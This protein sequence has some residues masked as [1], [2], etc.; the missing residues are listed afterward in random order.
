MTIRTLSTN[1]TNQTNLV[2]SLMDYEPFIVAHLVKFERPQSV[3]HYGGK[4]Q[5][6]ATDFT[7]ISDAQYDISFD[8]GGKTVSGASLGP[9]LYRANKL[10]K[11]GV[12]NESIQA[13]ASNL[14]LTLDSATLGISETI[15]ASFTSTHMTTNVDLAAEGFREGDKVLLTGSGNTNNGAYIRID[16]FSGEGKIVAFTQISSI[17]SNSSL[18]TYVISSASEEINSLITDKTSTSYTS[19]INRD[20]LIYRVHINPD[21]RAIIG[22]PY[23]YFKGIIGSADISEKLD[24]ST[25]TWKLASHWGD[26]IRVQGRLTDDASHRA[27]Q[28]G[29]DPDLTAVI[30]PEYA[31]DLGFLHANTAVN[32][33]ATYNTTEIEYKQVDINGSWFGGKR[34][35]E[36]EVIVPR[37]TDLQFNIQAKM[38]PVVYGVRK[39]DSFP[40]FVDTHKDTSAE[41]YRVDALCEGKIAGILDIH[42]EDNSTI[43]T[44]LPDFDLRNAS[45]A[46]YDS[47]SVEI[48]C[49]GRADRGDTMSHYSARAGAG[50]R[51][52][53]VDHTG[54]W[55]EIA[56]FFGTNF[57]IA[58]TGTTNPTSGSAT[59]ILHGGTH[60]ITSPLSASFSFYQGKPYQKADN[61]LVSLASANNFK[62]QN[63][64]YTG[65]STYWGA[66]HK[67]LDTAYCV[68]KYTI[69]EGETSLPDLKFIVRGRDPECYNYDGSYR[70]DATGAGAGN[71]LPSVFVLG[72]NVTLHRTDN[73]VAIGGTVQIVDKWS[74]FDSDGVAD[75]RFRWSVRPA[76]GTITAFYMKSGNS[77][78]HMQTWDHVENAG[79]VPAETYVTVASTTTG[80][81]AG[82][83]VTVNTPS[84]AL[85]WLLAQEDLGLA[86]YMGAFGID[87]ASAFRDY[88]AASGTVID[89]V[90]GLPDA[91]TGGDKIYV[92]DGITLESGA[93][94]ESGYYVGNTITVTDISG[95]LVYTQV[96][97]ITGYDGATRTATVDAVWDYSN[98]PNTSTKYVI[99]SIGDKRV[100]INPAMQLL[101]Y[102]TNDR[103]GKGL[104]IDK[105]IDLPVWIAAAADC[106]TRS[107]VSIVVPSSTSIIP[108]QKWRYPATGVLQ[109]Q[110]TVVSVETRG[111]YKEI[112][113]DDCIGKLGTKWNDWKTFAAGELYW[114]N[115]VAYNQGGAAGI[116]GTKPTGTSGSSAVTVTI[117]KVTDSTTANV[118]TSLVSAN[119][120][121][122]VK[123]YSASSLDYAASGYSLYD[124][125]DVKY[126]RYVGWDDPAQRFVTRHQTNQ[127]VATTNPLFDNINRM[128]SQFNGILRYSGGRYQLAVKGKK[129]VSVNVAEQISNDDIIGTIKLSDKGLKNSKNFVSTSII[130]PQNKFEGRSVSFFN[131]VYLK[132]DKGIQ[133]KGSFSLPGVTNYHNARFNIKQY[134]DESRYGLEI[135][136]RMA[137]RGLLLLAG[138]IIELTY[139]RFGYTAKEFRITNLNFTKDGLVDVTADEHNDSAYVVEPETHGALGLVSDVGSG[140]NTPA[141]VGIPNRPTGLVCTQNEQSAITLTWTNTA[142]FTVGTHFTEIYRSTVNNFADSIAGGSFVTGTKY[143]ILTL[144]ST[145]QAQWNTAA[146]STAEVYKAGDTIIAAGS[147]AGTGTV[148]RSL[149]V[150]SS[151]SDGYT[152]PITTGT[153]SQNRYYWIRYMNKQP[154][155]NRSGGQFRNVPSLYYPNT[156]DSGFT[157]GQ[158]VTGVGA[159]NNAV[160]SI[161]LSFGNTNTFVYQQDGTGIEAGYTAST[162][163]TATTTNVAG[164]PT[165][166]WKKTSKTGTVSIIN[167]ITGVQ[168][169]YSPPNAFTDIPETISVHMTDTIGSDTYTATDAVSFSGTKI[170]VNGTAGINGF[171][172]TATNGTHNFN[173]G[174]TGAI[175]STAPFSSSFT[176][177]KGATTLTYDGTGSPAA[178]TYRLGS[179]ANVSPANSVVPSNTNGAV[180]ISNSTGSFLTGNSV[181]QATFDVPIIENGSNTTI[182][183]FKI[184]LSKTLNGSLGI[185]S[186]LVYAYQRSGTTLTS[187]P[188]AV[189]VS[190]ETGKI[191]TTS[192][193]NGWYK[194]LSDATG[195]TP[196]YITAASA[197]GTG[198]T[199]T[200]PANEWTTPLLWTRN[201]DDGNPGINSA[202]VFIYKRTNS[203]SES[204]QPSGNTTY[205]FASGGVA[206][207]TANGW[208]SSV[209]NNTNTYVWTRQATAAS[210]S[211]TDVIPA[212]EWGP[213]VLTFA[214]GGTG[215]RGGSVFTFE[216][217]STSQISSTTATAWAGTLTTAAAQA[218]AAAVIASTPDGTIRANDRITI[219]DNSANKAG[220]RVYNGSA[221]TANTAVGTGDF[222]A[223]VV[224]T[225]D[226]SVIVD[227]TLSADKITANST[228]SNNITVGSTLILN[229]SGQFYTTNK[230]SYT[231]NDDGFFLGYTGG[232]HKLNLGGATN[233]IKWD[234]SG[235]VISGEIN[236]VGSSSIGGTAIATVTSGAASGA[237]ANQ[238]T[239]AQIQAGTTAAN[240]GLG[241]VDNSS[242]AT[243]QA[244][245]TAANVG[246]GNV[247]NSSAATIQ[248]GTTAA[249]VGLGNVDNTSDAT[250]VTAARAATTATDVGLGNATN[251]S[252]ATIQ[253]GTTAANVGLGNVS[254]TTLADVRAGVTAANVGL[255]NATNASAATIQAGTTAANVGLGNVN[256]TSDAT[257]LSGSLTGNVTG[258]VGGVA[259][260]TVNG[261]GA[262]AG[263]S[264]TAA[265]TV[266]RMNNN[267]LVVIDGSGVKRV[268]IGNLSAL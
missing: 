58:A 170:V 45:G 262:T 11:L 65:R 76:L 2:N 85:A 88:T 5:G 26:F 171:T 7:Y 234:G 231:D 124:S 117:K 152:D 206:F 225:F 184:N 43:C 163:L 259:V 256:N 159:A 218:A 37:T 19:Y 53:Q 46:N 16:T 49:Y 28:A 172:V 24:S 44:D 260:A 188:G 86:P 120:N 167:G 201:G 153:G 207:T 32:M 114:Y 89:N 236:M 267:G 118:N 228:F 202:T 111:S 36:V 133:K 185:S 254:N 66:N 125:D 164:T 253:A 205:T 175:S 121:P 221:T 226:G 104:D 100:T 145:T 211:T 241:N 110:G 39:I 13:K 63:D 200:I 82:T 35:K 180:T 112:I 3:A 135:Q 194:N 147:G 181:M 103:Y 126:W 116:I 246:L 84:A 213:A 69:A 60:T 168:Y 268:K 113:F 248:A 56:P 244:G 227:G 22:E 107:T 74:T 233:F 140:G 71:A 62:L 55:G 79:T 157:G 166:V 255:G 222:S 40:I 190:L 15:S 96:R 215:V 102:M 183:V 25:I 203:A 243:I 238:S 214:L 12:I 245:T 261:Y 198:T 14:S 223:L 50:T 34:L 258:N 156:S 1:S 137:P 177:L 247:D 192:L 106:D 230:T 144:G 23:I 197:A 9:Q 31:T 182:A 263:G 132:E 91:V 150:G 242:A 64:Y 92:K 142:A 57:N 77:K 149:L 30:R 6:L 176:V 232:K 101:D 33:M 265:N 47:E 193:G 143:R 21:T 216:E 151:T 155:L 41:V 219:T 266:S 162:I 90:V 95:A 212:S 136:F 179:F 67:L 204:T 174:P 240:V 237:T 220:T 191:T 131:S 48:A 229:N 154:V 52:R 196:L 75:H 54:R 224:E 38:L 93:S 81:A 87:F 249:N 134:L 141:P 173:A 42:I 195:T 122:I 94:D 235:L 83:K 18:Q 109:W 178:N 68:G 99:G 10:L 105:D 29:G 138:S 148:T 210:T 158:G 239:N 80:T 98:I 161:K 73:N 8:D 251:S 189:A 129:P 169:T 72:S 186:A 257:V 108:T 128:L 115:G 70:A 252:A 78:W 59:G 250:V 217:S 17:T 127:V 165:Y 187:N 61:T 4:V 130:D 27:L 160:R 209:P 199:D 264:Q 139:P 123:A 20:V 119:G 97:K 208:S 146:G 51:Q